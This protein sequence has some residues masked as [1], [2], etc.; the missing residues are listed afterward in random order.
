MSQNLSSAAAVIGSL[1]VNVLHKGKLGILAMTTG[2]Q[3]VQASF[4]GLEA[5][6]EDVIFE[7]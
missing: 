6:K 1:R 2:S 4:F 3:N 7:F 5:L